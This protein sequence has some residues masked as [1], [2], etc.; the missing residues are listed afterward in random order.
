MSLA[1]QVDALAARIRTEFNSVRTSL[2]EKASLDDPRLSDARTPTPHGHVLSDPAISGTLPITQAPTPASGVEASPIQLVRGSDPRLTDARVPTSHDHPVTAILAGGRTPANFLRGD[3][4]W[5]TPTNT[6]YST[7]SQAEAESS[8]NTTPR[9]STGQRLYQ[10]IAAHARLSSW[11][12]SVTDISATG[13]TTSN[14]LR[15]DGTWA[16]PPGGVYTEIS[17]AEAESS[18]ST[19]AGLTTGQ[20]MYQAITKWAPQTV[21]TGV[22]QMWAGLSLGGI[23]DPPPGWLICRGQLESRALYPDLYALIGDAYGLNDGSTN[24]CVPNFVRRRPMGMDPAVFERWVGG[25][26][27]SETA[28]V[29]LPAHTH[30]SGTLT[31]ASNGTHSHIVTRRANSGTV[32][33]TY[34]GGGATNTTNNRTNDDG[35]HTH[36]VSGST[37]TTGVTNPSIDIE[38]PW[39]SIN[40]IIKT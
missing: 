7:M 23:G 13:R 24:F 31:A 26:G 17:Q 38:D 35:A 16:T 4:N 2:A 36:S 10:A 19:T 29:P 25:T 32:E 39:E 20:R 18:T 33:G 12:P 22:V 9:L 14:Y 27:G 21:P 15:G 34:S 8:A 37:S 40:F 30:G 5:A 6:T 11:V 28:T 1:S 3:G